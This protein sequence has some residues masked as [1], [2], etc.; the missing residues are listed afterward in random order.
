MC[1]T[2]DALLR[3]FV[4][5]SFSFPFSFLLVCFPLE[6]QE[7]KDDDNVHVV[8]VRRVFCSG[9]TLVDVWLGQAS[10]LG[11]P[12]TLPFC[13][14]RDYPNNR[15]YLHTSLRTPLRRP[16]IEQ[17]EAGRRHLEATLDGWERRG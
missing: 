9:C 8:D 4:A 15:P 12:T 1:Q 11:F 5:F 2:D 6:H 7:A 3:A 13:V 17:E 14:R 10:G 16:G